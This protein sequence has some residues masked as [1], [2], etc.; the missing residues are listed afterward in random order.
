MIKEKAKI[1]YIGTVHKEGDSDYGV[2]FYDFPGCITVGKTI[3]EAQIMAHEALKG[4]VSC[5]IAD[6]DIIPEPSSLETIFEDV[7][8]Q[9]AIAFIVINIVQQQESLTKIFNLITK[10]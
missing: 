9:D 6:G 7:D 3:E 10:L 4:H 2:Q 8:H 5:M 1:K